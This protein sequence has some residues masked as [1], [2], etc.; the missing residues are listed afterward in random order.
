LKIENQE[1]RGQE[2]RK[3]KHVIM[4]R[5]DSLGRVDRDNVK[6][7]TEAIRPKIG[8]QNAD[9]VAE[10]KQPDQAKALSLDHVW[11]LNSAHFSAK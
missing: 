4:E 7:K 5:R 2:K 9:N 8:D 11:P 10:N 3:N 6:I 1:M